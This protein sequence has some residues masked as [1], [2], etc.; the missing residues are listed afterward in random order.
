MFKGQRARTKQ[1]A[2]VFDPPPSIKVNTYWGPLYNGELFAIAEKHGLTGERFL[3]WITPWV[4]SFLY[5]DISAIEAGVIAA[6]IGTDEPGIK[7][8]K[9]SRTTQEIAYQIMLPEK[10]VRAAI[11][12][13]KRKGIIQTE[14]KKKAVIPLLKDWLLFRHNAHYANIA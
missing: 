12:R 14:G 4:K 6:M 11:Y 10:T 7:D 5:K 13:L 2:L 9:I 3:D 1:L 8:G